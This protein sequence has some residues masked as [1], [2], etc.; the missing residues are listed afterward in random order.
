EIWNEWTIATGMVKYRNQVPS[1]NVYYNLVKK[2][3]EVIKRN[4]P[5]AII[6]AG[7]INPL[8]LRARYIDVNDWKWFEQL[9]NLGI[10][11]YIDGVS[12]HTYS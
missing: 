4:D 3:S 10:L 2:T 8:D 12:L 6:L 1:A 9:V 7:S 11:N 5:N